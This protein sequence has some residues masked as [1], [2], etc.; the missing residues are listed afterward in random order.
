MVPLMI[1][2]AMLVALLASTWLRVGYCEPYEL[3]LM[4]IKFYRLIAVL[5]RDYSS[6]SAA[7]EADAF[8]N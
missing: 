4:A 8:P 2:S 5:G 1:G 3:L 6:D 7:S